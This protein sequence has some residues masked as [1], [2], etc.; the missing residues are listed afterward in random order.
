[1]RSADWNL[2]APLGWAEAVKVN[3]IV[4]SVAKPLWKAFI[5]IP[6]AQA[7]ELRRQRKPVLWMTIG[8]AYVLGRFSIDQWPGGSSVLQ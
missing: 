2:N 1:M 5:E 3:T 8:F 4:K 6:G 7:K